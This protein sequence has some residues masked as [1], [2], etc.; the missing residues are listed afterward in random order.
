[1]II[2]CDKNG[3]QGTARNIGITYSSGDYVSF[4]DSD[5]W[6]RKDMY[7]ILCR[8]MDDSKCDIVQFRYIGKSNYEDTEDLI[9]EI[10]YKKYMILTYLTKE[11]NMF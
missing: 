1:M 9:S 7:E 10:K 8:I 11:K 3:K 5:D 4:V 6:I 2:L